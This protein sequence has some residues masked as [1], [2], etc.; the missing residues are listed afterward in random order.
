M[1]PPKIIITSFIS[2]KV[3]DHIVKLMLS[4]DRL[5]VCKHK[6][7]RSYPSPDGTFFSRPNKVRWRIHW[8]KKNRDNEIFHKG[9]WSCCS[10]VDK[11][12]IDL[13]HGRDLW[14]KCRMAQLHQGKELNK[15]LP[16]LFLNWPWLS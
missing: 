4:I 7:K 10:N 12:S 9:F 5:E 8:K 11:L 6:R 15:F 1:I 3:S 14:F 13:F 2:Y 16:F